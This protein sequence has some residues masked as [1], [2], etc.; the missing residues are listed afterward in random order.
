MSKTP[1]SMK[2]KSNPTH[3]FT[4]VELLVVITIIGILIALLLPAVQAAREAARRLQCTNNLKQLGLAMLNHEEVHGFFPSGG[5]GWDW[6]GDPD[7]GTGLQQPAGWSY[8]ILPYLEQQALHDLGSDGDPTVVTQTQRDGVVTREQTPLAMFN[9]PSR[10]ANIIYPRPRA[11]SGQVSYQ[12]GPKF[13]RSAGLEYCV[14]AGGSGLVYGSWTPG[15]APLDD[16][17]VSFCGS[18][19]SLSQ[20]EDG[21]SCTIMLGEKYIWPDHYE[22][23]LDDGDDHGM[24]EGEGVDQSR[25]TYCAQG[26]LD[27]W[28]CPPLQETP[29]YKQY[30]CFG[31][32]HPNSCNF[33]MC[34]GSVQWINY[35]IKPEV[36]AN[37]GTRDDQNVID[38]KEW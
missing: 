21:T 14:N 36:Y 27:S 17:G 29:G 7:A 20:I 38:A 30:W 13:S 31:S 18:K 33:T 28:S 35:T 3:G 11:K 32:P 15:S 8:T 12:N 26:M 6:T 4:L 9:C 19:L 22:T 2:R 10:R 23:G 5:W 1:Y 24:Y 25:W 16:G 37:L 34:D